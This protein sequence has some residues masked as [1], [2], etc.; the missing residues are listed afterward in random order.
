V[1]ESTILAVACLTAIAAVAVVMA[2][3]LRRRSETDCRVFEKLA[4]QLIANSDY[5]IKRLEIEA[6]LADVHAKER[7]AQAFIQKARNF[8]PQTFN[9]DLTDGDTP[10][11]ETTPR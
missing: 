5:Q 6:Q 7:A 10:E 3:S 11:F 4:D 9:G 8:S 1:N 2:I